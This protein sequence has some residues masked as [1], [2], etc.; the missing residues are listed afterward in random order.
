MSRAKKI[1]ICTDCNTEQELGYG[2]Y[3]RA[4]YEARYYNRLSMPQRLKSRNY[5]ENGIGIITD[6]KGKKH[7]LTL[8]EFEKAPKISLRGCTHSN[9]NNKQISLIKYNRFY[10]S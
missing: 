8:E 5:I 3:C 10:F 2:L 4:C 1:G 7:K 9:T 6:S